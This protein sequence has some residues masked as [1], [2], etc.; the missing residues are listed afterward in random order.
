MTD[1]KVLCV[2]QQSSVQCGHLAMGGESY[3]CPSRVYG[4]SLV[5]RAHLDYRKRMAGWEIPSV[6]ELETE[7]EP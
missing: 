1:W 3:G 7:P 2:S 6:T 5:L 4:W